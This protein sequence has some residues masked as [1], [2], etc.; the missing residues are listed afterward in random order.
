M[1]NIIKQLLKF[2]PVILIT[3]MILL[4]IN[5]LLQ[6]SANEELNHSFLLN[7]CFLCIFLIIMLLM[8]YVN[9]NFVK[10]FAKIFYILSII[11]ATLVLLF[12]LIKH[13][14]S[15]WLSFGIIHLQP[16]EI[17][18]LSVPIMISSYLANQKSLSLSHY[19]I[20]LLIVIIPFI[21]VV[22]QP[23]LGTACLIL[24]SALCVLFLAGF[25]YKVILYIF[26]IFCA[27]SPIL[28]HLL[29]DY[30][31]HR[32][33]MLFN[34]D[35]DPLNHG[36][37]VIQ[38]MIAIGS[39]GLVGKGYLHGTQVHLN[40]IPEKTT[41]SIVS[42]LGEEFGFIGVCILIATY[43]VMVLRGIK[44]MRQSDDMFMYLVSGFISMS[45]A[46]YVFI[47]MGMISG[48]L[49]VVGIPLPLI[50]HG[51]TSTL[52]TSLSIGLLLSIDR[53]NKNLI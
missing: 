35:I 3:V 27:T 37:H 36:Y 40:F 7:I 20:A 29:H 46:F 6:Y 38:S 41:D 1:R 5:L 10:R 4:T 17:C 42:I 47:N 13:G 31:R 52:L 28:W 32:I 50:S 23:D 51:G 26:I 15:R 49:P 8:S 18:K 25:P 33:L 19:L 45:L 12:G 11:L 48:I 44:I 14:S 16:S 9:I 21:L 24:Y 53:H 34:P 22:K 30:Q 2:D 43:L 39:G